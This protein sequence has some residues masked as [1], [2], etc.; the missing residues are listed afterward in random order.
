LH[1][2]SLILSTGHFYLARTGH[3]HL[4]PTPVGASLIFGG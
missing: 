2:P 4:A 3:S 1:L